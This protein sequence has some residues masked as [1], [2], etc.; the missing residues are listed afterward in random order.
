MSDTPLNENA[1]V[2]VQDWM[3]FKDATFGLHW[4]NAKPI[5]ETYL[6]AVHT[7]DEG[8]VLSKIKEMHSERL[9]PDIYT[10]LDNGSTK[11]IST[12]K[13]CD[14]GSWPCE[15]YRLADQGLGSLNA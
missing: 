6:N 1:L 11:H 10:Y 4:M 9:I 8:S 15:T 5:I 2:V 3:K 7:S 14:L 13:V 12:C